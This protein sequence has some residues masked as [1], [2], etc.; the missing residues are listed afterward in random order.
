MEIEQIVQ[1]VEFTS[2]M[3]QIITTL[4]FLLGDILTGFICAIINKNLDSQKMREGLLRKMLLIVVMGL[5]FC[6]Q[7]AIFNM[8]IISKAV[9]IYIIIMEIVSILE[10]LQKAGI[11]FGK[12]GNIFKIKGDEK[13]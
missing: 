12:F 8:T 9:C 11:D 13:E 10:N 4:I 7:Y 1:N 6:L 3:W 2:V 5:S